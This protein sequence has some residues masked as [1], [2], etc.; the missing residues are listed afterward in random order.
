MD[1]VNTVTA[2]MGGA[3]LACLHSLIDWARVVRRLSGGLVSFM[4]VSEM[5]TRGGIKGQFGEYAADC[6]LTATHEKYNDGQRIVD[7]E[8]RRRGGGSGALGFHMIDWQYGVWRQPDE[9]VGPLH[10]GPG[11]EWMQ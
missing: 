9:T 8:V 2:S 5:N 6:L 3:Y 4:L 10:R 11:E 7:L 1:S